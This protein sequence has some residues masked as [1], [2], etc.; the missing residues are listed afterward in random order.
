VAEIVV[1]SAIPNASTYPGIIMIVIVTTVV[2]S[3]IGIPIFTRPRIKLQE[4]KKPR[5]KSVS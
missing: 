5:S 4:S 1:A 3:A 2:I